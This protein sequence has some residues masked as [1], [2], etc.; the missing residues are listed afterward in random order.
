MN[1]K[2]KYFKVFSLCIPVKGAIR[3]AIYDLQR[4]EFK[5]IPNTLYSI[6]EEYNGKTIEEVLENFSDED[7]KETVREY[8]NFLVE[9]DYIFFCD[10]D[11]LELFPDLEKEYNFPGTISNAIIDIG[12]LPEERYLDLLTYLEELGCLDIVLRFPKSCSQS[13]VYDLCDA[14]KKSSIKSIDIFLNFD[15]SIDLSE[16]ISTF[17]RIRTITVTG[18]AKE[19][20]KVGSLGRGNIHYTTTEFESLDRNFEI[21]KSMLTSNIKMFME[22]QFYHTY[23]NK[24]LFIDIDGNIKNSPESDISFGQLMNISGSA[25]LNRIVDSPKFKKLWEVKKDETEVCK[26]CELRYMCTDSRVP[27]A[28]NEGEWTHEIDCNYNPFTGKWTA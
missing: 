17:P 2:S 19:N 13:Q 28:N 24:K 25:E 6:L 3:S 9:N 8:F 14:L 26:D 27:I 10:K 1:K 21:D 4:N 5:F 18:A 15:E 16:I 7:D 11:E 23:L 22:A 12:N 20:M